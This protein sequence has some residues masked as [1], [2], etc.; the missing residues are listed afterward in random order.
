MQ[1]GKKQK[2]CGIELLVYCG[3]LILAVLLL[4]LQQL[5]VE[6]FFNELR[7]IMNHQTIIEQ[8][9]EYANCIVGTWHNEQPGEVLTFN[10]LEN[11]ALES[12]MITVNGDVECK[13]TYCIFIDADEHWY[14]QTYV[15]G[16]KSEKYC[17]LVLSPNVM[18]LADEHNELSIY[19]R[20]VDYGFVYSV[21]DQL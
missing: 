3:G 20:K 11:I 18:A 13:A 6:S 1:Q 15:N 19:M 16:Q 12:D 17:I 21:L 9:K 10:L 4:S 2:S 14:L 7:H 5:L 8:C